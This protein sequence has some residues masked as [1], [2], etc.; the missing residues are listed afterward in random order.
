ML[1]AGGGAGGPPN[2]NGG[3]KPPGGGA[4]G[5]A[6][7][8][9]G[10]LPPTAEPSICKLWPA[11]P[12]APTS[13]A[14]VAV[15]VPELATDAIGA[16]VVA[17]AAMCDTPC[18][19][20]AMAMVPPQERPMRFPAAPEPVV[21]KPEKAPAIPAIPGSLPSPTGAEP[22]IDVPPPPTTGSPSPAE[23]VR[24]TERP[25]LRCAGGG[26]VFLG[27]P[28]GM[29]EPNCCCEEA[30]ECSSPF[31]WGGKPA[32]ESLAPPAPALALASL[33]VPL[34]PSE[35][36]RFARNTRMSNTPSAAPMSG[37]VA[38]CNVVAPSSPLAPLPRCPTPLSRSAPP[39]ASASPIVP[40]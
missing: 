1:L 24:G 38:C 12:V 11:A 7:V 25:P 15:E 35:A 39:L 17:D 8:P 5:V 36:P 14:P 26:R 20:L 29:S 27:A 21:A 9:T 22:H 30:A 34:A 19:A 33:P 2:P 32:E 37:S 16:A 23:V 3:M 4:M 40:W 18:G 28:N 6:V 31:M 13:C 10:A